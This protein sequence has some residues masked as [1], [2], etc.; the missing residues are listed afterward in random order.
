MDVRVHNCVPSRVRLEAQSMNYRHA[1][2]AG[3]FA[4][5][6]KHVVLALCLEHLKRKDKPFALIDT[7][8]GIGLYDLTSDAARRSPEWRDGLGRVL[9]GD[10]PEGARKT[11][12]PWLDVV[13]AMNAGKAEPESYP[14]SPEIAARLARPQ[15][16]IHLCELHDVDSKTLDKRYALD[17]RVKVEQRDGYKALKALLPPREKRGLVL[18]DPPFESR[19]EFVRLAE[20]AMRGLERWPTGT[21]I[22]W[23][24]MKDLWSLDRFDEGLA[25]WLVTERDV[26][27]EAI[28][29]ADMWV[30]DL[31]SE[32]RLAGAGVVIIN[33]PH[34]LEADLLALLPWLSETLKQGEGAG[35]RLDGIVT[36][37]MAAAWES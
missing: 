13:N 2:H 8:A 31:Q 9:A 26:E 5:V 1:F 32:G 4:D 12:T 33:P 29:R 30:R 22:F 15:D 11:L 35:W 3:N 24:P 25:E 10:M 14:G 23:R 20:A 7:H 21:F 17:R 37:E 28:L 27:P 6:L 34:G 19:D 16:R 18:I 36:E